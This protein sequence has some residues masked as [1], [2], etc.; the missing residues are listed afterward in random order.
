MSKNRETRQSFFLTAIEDFESSE[1]FHKVIGNYGIKDEEISKLDS[2]VW[3]EL[4]NKTYWRIID[5]IIRPII[6]KPKNNTND[7]S[8]EI[9]RVD[10]YKILSCTEYAIMLQKSYVI[11]KNLEATRILNAGL[12]FHTAFLFLQ[13]WNG[14]RS[15]F[16]NKEKAIG[17]L[18]S[19]K[20]SLRDDNGSV[21]TIEEEHIG[22]IAVTSELVNIPFLTNAMWWRTICLYIAKI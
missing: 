14:Y 11:D 4:V 12:A 5:T 22:V 2:I 18:F 3:S 1:R 20:E 10:L 16:V 21:M 15:Y 7:S 8:L 13:N 17:E 6:E 9:D 19:Y